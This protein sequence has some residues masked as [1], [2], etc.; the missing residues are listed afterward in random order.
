[1]GLIDWILHPSEIVAL[2]RYTMSTATSDE[3]IDRVKDGK[4][5]KMYEFLELTSRSFTAVIQALHPELRD[6]V[7]IFYLVLRG[8]DT[9]EDDMGIDKDLKLTLLESLHGYIFQPGWK[10]LGSSPG[11]KDAHLLVEFDLV[12]DQFLALKPEYRE[13]IADI[14][15]KMGYGMA[16]FIRGK[17]VVTTEDYDLY[18]HYVAGLVG[19]GLSALFAAS[20]LEDADMATSL[21]L[22]NSMGLFL[23]K[24]NIIRDVLEDTL[25]KRCFWPRNI[26]AQYTV[27]GSKD[28]V[29]GN[30]IIE[31]LLLPENKQRSMACL[32]HMCLNA[33]QHIPDVIT[34]LSKLKE[35]SV[36]RF[37]AI[38]QLMAIATL[39]LVFN[40]YKV[41]EKNVKIRKGEAVSL[42][43][44]STNVEEAKKVFIEYLDKISAKSSPNDPNYAKFTAEVGKIKAGIRAQMKEDPYKN[45]CAVPTLLV[46]A[47]F[48]G[49]AA[50]LYTNFYQVL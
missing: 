38:P 48:I 34:Y 46:L 29:N 20:K 40:N 24:T 25:D 7:C 8:L 9:I 35:P 31:E 36:Y 44:R 10:F 19:E 6:A 14:T 11:E 4:K 18:C 2:F 49:I 30:P 32:N 23:Q 50:I 47:I 16:D 26:W 42:I 22:S 3:V 41:F 45:A 28:P 43:M 13:I 17:K 39:T 27:T 15:K 1:M 5:A 37:C 12:I 33:L 21:E